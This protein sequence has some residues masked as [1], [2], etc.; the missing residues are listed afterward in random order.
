MTARP[1]D[2]DVSSTKLIQRPSGACRAAETTGVG[3]TLQPEEVDS[4]QA[5]SNDGWDDASRVIRSGSTYDPN[6][7]TARAA[8]AGAAGAAALASL[9]DSATGRA[10]TVRLAPL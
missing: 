5:V 8:G 10:V 2:R 7:S 1:A 3:R 9:W 4:V 6:P